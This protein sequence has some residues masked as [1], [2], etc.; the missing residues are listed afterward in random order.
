MEQLIKNIFGPLNKKIPGFLDKVSEILEKKFEHSIKNAK[1][2][3]SLK[4][5]HANILKESKGDFN[6]EKQRFIELQKEYLD[7]EFKIR[8]P[9]LSSVRQDKVWHTLLYTGT[10]RI[11]ND[12]IKLGIYGDKRLEPSTV[13]EALGFWDSAYS[14]DEER[15]ILLNEVSQ[16]QNL[17]PPNEDIYQVLDILKSEMDSDSFRNILLEVKN[18]LKEDIVEYRDHLYFYNLAKNLYCPKAKEIIVFSTTS[19]LVIPSEYKGYLSTKSHYRKEYFDRG[20]KSSSPTVY[21]QWDGETTSKQL[22]RYMDGVFNKDKFN[23]SVNLFTEFLLKPNIIISQGNFNECPLKKYFTI[24]SPSFG[25]LFSFRDDEGTGKIMEGLL[26]DLEIDDDEH[27]WCGD[28]NGNPPE[29]STRLWDRANNFYHS[30]DKEMIKDEKQIFTKAA[31]A[32]EYAEAQIHKLLCITRK[33][34]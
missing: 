6:P 30:N 1:R 17:E 23:K 31:E 21:Y 11:E 16:K 28:F 20:I 24:S 34:C 10:V 25:T 27:A 14:V 12:D 4:K 26:L 2:L 13:Y 19:G 29:S 15:N 22:W 8:A 32:K 7:L 5:E 9:V 3:E 18:A 33:P